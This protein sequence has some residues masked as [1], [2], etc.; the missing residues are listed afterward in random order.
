MRSVARVG[1]RVVR[2][3]AVVMVLLGTFAGSAHAV[4]YGQY[5]DYVYK[6]QVG[7]DNY[8]YINV[9]GNFTNNH[10]CSQPF[11]ARSTYLLSDNRTK[12]WMQLATASLLSHT[13]VY[14][15]TNGCTPYGHP[16]MNLLQ[17]E[18]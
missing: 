14:I 3:V 12:A 9:L 2:Y 13:R 7:N 5:Y 17:L 6:V 4:E 18:Q 11:F 15:Q 1:K 8:L 16:I 10:G